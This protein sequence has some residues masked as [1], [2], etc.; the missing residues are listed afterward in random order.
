LYDEYEL[1]RGIIRLLNRAVAA[2]FSINDA[3]DPERIEQRR[4]VRCRIKCAVVRF[5]QIS[6]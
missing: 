5:R 2:A 1:L 3:I 6:F 4:S